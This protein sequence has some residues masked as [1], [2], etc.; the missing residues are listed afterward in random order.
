MLTSVADLL[1]IASLSAKALCKPVMEYYEHAL[2]GNED[3]KILSRTAGLLL[4]KLFAG[5]VFPLALRP[6]L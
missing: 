6:W 2:H 1:G 4:K 5:G 3:T